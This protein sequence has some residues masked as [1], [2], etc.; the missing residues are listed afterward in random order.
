MVFYFIFNFKYFVVVLDIDKK[1]D[2]KCNMKEQ[3][4]LRKISNNLSNEGLRRE[5]LLRNEIFVLE[6]ISLDYEYGDRI[7]CDSIK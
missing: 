4:I 6:K 5:F 3:F 1:Y 7:Y 2:V